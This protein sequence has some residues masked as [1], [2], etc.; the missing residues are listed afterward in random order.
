MKVI[1][2]REL[3]HD[4]AKWLRAAKEEQE[5]VV[6]SRGVP[7][8]KLIPIT[9]SPKKRKTWAERTL[10]PGYAALM[11]AGKLKTTGDSSIGIS[12]DRT[13][14]DNGVAGIEE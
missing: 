1:S 11:K 13:S 12:E 2:V 10:L 5:I 3:H 9:E 14:R 7:L 4:T 8:V 6:T